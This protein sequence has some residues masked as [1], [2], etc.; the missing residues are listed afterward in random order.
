M[1]AVH[2]VPPQLMGIIP[3]NTGGFGDIEKASKVFVRNELMPL[4]RR[5]EELN[6]WLG[7]EVIRFK[8]YTLD[9]TD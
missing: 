8:K 9:E 3:N 5:F 4:Q 2:R 1:L 7:E 6:S